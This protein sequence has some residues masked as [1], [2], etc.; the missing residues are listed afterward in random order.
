MGEQGTQSDG[1]MTTDD[2]PAV[3]PAEGYVP[4]LT[5]D[6]T[7]TRKASA[8]RPPTTRTPTPRMPGST[9]P[10]SA[11]Y[12][13]AVAI[14]AIVVATAGWTTVA[15]MALN[16]NDNGGSAAALETPAASDAVVDPNASDD[17]GTDFSDAPVDDSHDAPD[18]EALLPT[19][20]GDTALSLQSWTG[21]S[22]LTAG[23]PWSDSVTAFLTTVGKTPADLSAAQ[24][25]DAT[26]ATDHSVGVFRLDGVPTKA[27]RD[28][29]IAAWKESYPDL[30]VST[31][32]LDGTEVTKG[33]FGQDAIDS[34]WYEKDGLVYDIETS[35]EKVATTLVTGIRDGTL[36]TGTPAAAGSEAP[37]ESPAPS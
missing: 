16:N 28:A 17:P 30:K 18:L 6:P 29:M 32:K 9:P 35:D 34:Y 3:D 27:L 24:A 26:E 37:S 5:P 21:D 23:D 13:P 36:P 25:F 20:I 2:G 15:V 7:S 8:P 33:D 14:I 22:L 12:W 31:I 10:R 4:G 19:A 11:G 1:D